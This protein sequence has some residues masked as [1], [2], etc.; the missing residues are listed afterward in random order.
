MERGEPRAMILLMTQQQ[1]LFATCSDSDMWDRLLVTSTGPVVD[2]FGWTTFSVVEL[3]QTLHN[4]DT[5]ARAD[6]V[7]HTTKM[8]PFHV[9]Q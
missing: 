2:R 7:V 9:P 3:K 4:V 6:T 8:F 5:T 1:E